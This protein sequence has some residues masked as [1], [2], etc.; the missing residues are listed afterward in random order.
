MFFSRLDDVPE[1]FRGSAEVN[2]SADFH[3]RTANE[4]RLLKHPFNH[5]LVL[6]AFRVQRQ[7]FETGASEIKHFRRLSSPEQ[8]L[9]LAGGKGV[10]EKITLVYIDLLLREKLPRFPAGGSLLPAIEI[11]FHMKTASPV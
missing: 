5:I 7:F 8:R 3:D 11:N 2:F 1:L 4:P 9:D 6:K 10:F